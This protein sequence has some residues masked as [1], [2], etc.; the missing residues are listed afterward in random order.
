MEK[1]KEI[2]LWLETKAKDNGVNYTISPDSDSEEK[3][4][5]QIRDLSTAIQSQ[6]EQIFIDEQILET[7]LS[8]LE[9]VRC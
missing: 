5:S 6:A 3:L 8:K 4:Y 2:V 1:L 7:V 9:A